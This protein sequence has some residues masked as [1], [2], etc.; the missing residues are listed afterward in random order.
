MANDMTV[1]EMVEEI[2]QSVLASPKHQR[3]L[4]S[5]TFWG[6]FGFKVRTKER[7][8]Q[9]YECLQEHGLVT[10]INPENFG[11]E[12][13]DDWLILTYLEMP[14]PPVVEAEPKVST[15]IETP[16]P[17]WFENLSNRTFE[18]E[19]E[20]EY[21]FIM[22]LIEQLGYKEADCTMGY[23]VL[24]HQGRKKATKVADIV[25]FDGSSRA[26]GNALLVI[27]AKKPGR[28]ISNDDVGQARSY[29]LWLT[30]T[31]YLITNGEQ[32]RLY[33]FR[34]A[35]QPDAVLLSI[36]REQLRERWDLI[37]LTLNKE[38][39]ISYKRAH[40]QS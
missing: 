16:S 39:V 22:P 8:Q 2:Y 30:P 25:L 6:K 1:A 17:E 28:G 24:M 33:I 29:A 35:V 19:R 38:A 13:K 40:A 34:G 37:Y 15:A 12:G 23:P 20:V 4:L 31:Y 32:L 26:V 3:R 36:T 9:V 27:E 21:Y 10:N 11:T 5:K 14:L 18:S 7:V